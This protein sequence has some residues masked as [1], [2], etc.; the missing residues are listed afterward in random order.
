MEEQTRAPQQRGRG[1]RPAAQVRAEV[2]AAA[3]GLLLDGGMGAFTFER[4]FRTVWSEQ[5]DAL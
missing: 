4:V 2:L 1:R 3:G 5:G